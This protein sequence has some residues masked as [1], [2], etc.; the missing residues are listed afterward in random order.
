MTN[1]MPEPVG[2]VH[3]SEARAVMVREPGNLK[4]KHSAVQSPLI[5]YTDTISQSKALLARWPEIMQ[6]AA[7]KAQEIID[8]AVP[9]PA[10]PEEESKTDG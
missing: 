10:T 8:A 6:A 7:D 2:P 3:Y 5:V 1:P 9:D 4:S